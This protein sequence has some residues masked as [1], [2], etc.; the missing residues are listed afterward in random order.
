MLG[1]GNAS[2]D[3][4]KLIVGMEH[5]TDPPAHNGTFLLADGKRWSRRRPIAELSDGDADWISAY[6]E[7][8]TE[9]MVGYV[10]YP[11]LHF[12]RMLPNVRT[13]WCKSLHVKEISGLL[14]LSRLEELRV[15]RSTCRMEVV[16]ELTT[17]QRL[18][19][20]D[21]RPGAGSIFALPNLR[22]F[23]AQKFGFP[24]LTGMAGWHHLRELSLN[25]GKLERLAGLPV[26]VR[27]LDLSSLRK[28]SSLSGVENCRGPERLVIDGCRPLDSLQ[29]LE[30]CRELKTL[31]LV[32]CGPMR[33]LDPLR[34]MEGLEYVVLVQGAADPNTDISALYT[35]PGLKT[36]I[37]SRKAGLDPARVKQVAPA[38]DVR[39]V[40]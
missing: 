26:T 19:L 14:H 40:R 12:L 6:A 10:E 8:V 23:G 1:W 34:G 39:L 18:Y 30:A 15:D 21:W 31:S 7:R 20:D 4:L 32:S 38:C 33:N 17:L 16:G 22:R 35:L 27:E 37:I 25:A 28:F 24:D 29:G 2:G 13:V 3:P 36:L 11:N 5:L 9:V